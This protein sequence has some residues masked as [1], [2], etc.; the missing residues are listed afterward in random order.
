MLFRFFQHVI[1]RR[2][3][4]FV[5]VRFAVVFSHRVIDKLVPHQNSPQIGMTLEMDPVEIENFS[6][7]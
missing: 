5:I 3:L 2:R 6:L 4:P 7:L 1:V